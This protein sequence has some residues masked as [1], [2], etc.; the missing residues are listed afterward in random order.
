M[1]DAITT[2]YLVEVCGL[3]RDGILK[4]IKVSKYEALKVWNK[5]AKMLG[6]LGVAI[7]VWNSAE[8]RYVVLPWS[9]IVEEVAYS[10]KKNGGPSAFANDGNEYWP[11]PWSRLTAKAVLIGSWE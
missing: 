6:L 1:P 4:S 9:A 3:G 7:F 10:K 5:I 11:I 2:T 8:R